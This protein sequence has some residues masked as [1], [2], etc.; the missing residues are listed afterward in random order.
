MA[1]YRYVPMRRCAGGTRPWARCSSPCA[2]GLA[3]QALGLY[4][5]RVPTYS[6]HLRHLATVPILLLWI[7]LGWLIVLWGAVIA[8]CLLAGSVRRASGPGWEFQLACEALQALARTAAKPPT[9]WPC[10][11]WRGACRSIPWRCARC[12]TRCR[13]WADG[14]GSP[15]P[16]TLRRRATCCW[17]TPP[18]RRWHRCWTGCCWRPMRRLAGAGATRRGRR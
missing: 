13:R 10:P 17:P 4:L 11:S 12:W 16:P 8:Y 1:L 3:R 18:P 15:A 6:G 2:L 14:P 5:S 7:Y 9:A